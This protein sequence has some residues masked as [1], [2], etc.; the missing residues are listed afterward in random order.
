MSVVTSMPILEDLLGSADCVLFDFDGPLARLFDQYPASGV[1]R[2]LKAWLEKREALIP[3]ARDC[4]DPLR[5]LREFTGPEH[6]T[7]V[8]QL[9]T[10]HEVH[11]ASVATPTD[12][13]DELV[14]VLA[15]RGRSVAVTTNNSPLLLR[16]TSIAG[17]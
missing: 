12:H 13:A 11:A 14:Q 8:E 4:Q 6:Y 9:L 2:Q 10:K 16:P 17:G 5:V 3:E 15:S 7:E 1:A